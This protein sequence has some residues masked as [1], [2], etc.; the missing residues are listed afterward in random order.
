MQVLRFLE[1]RYCTLEARSYERVVALH[2]NRVHHTHTML[3]ALSMFKPKTSSEMSLPWISFVCNCP[4]KTNS[5][6]SPSTN[7]ST[8]LEEHPVARARPTKPSSSVAMCTVQK[9]VGSTTMVT[10]TTGGGGGGPGIWKH[11]PVPM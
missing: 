4:A 1:L 5:P 11:V 6:S 3:V 2:S 9:S 10:L 7:A 8:S